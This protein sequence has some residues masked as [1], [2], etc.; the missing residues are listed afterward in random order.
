M[1]LEAT[2]AP[3]EHAQ[4]VETEMGNAIPD[5]T[6]PQEFTPRKKPQPKTYQNSSK[7]NQVSKRLDKAVVSEKASS[8]VSDLSPSEADEPMDQAPKAASRGTKRQLSKTIVREPTKLSTRTKRPVS[9]KGKSKATSSADESE[10]SDLTDI[11][12]EK[13]GG[14]GAAAGSG[15]DQ[16][17]SVSIADLHILI[18]LYHSQQRTKQTN[19]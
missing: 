1:S 12:E 11:G 15:K 4:P 3:G 5:L 19:W 10:G 7:R 2:S 17:T 8:D 13:K 16:R 6:L 18:A 9:V 14:K